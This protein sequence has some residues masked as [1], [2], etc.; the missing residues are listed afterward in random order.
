[1]TLGFI[2]GI[3]RGVLLVSIAYLLL[4]VSVQPNDRPAWIR[5]AKSEPYLQQGADLLR[6]MLP[7]QF[8]LRSASAAD[9]LIRSVDPRDDAAALAALGLHALQHRGQEAAGIVAYDGEQFSAHRG[10]GL[11][12]D[13][14]S[15][16]EVID[17][18]PG[19][20][21]IGHV[22][23]ATT[24][25]VAPRNIQPL[26]ADFEFGGLA[27]CHNGNLTNSY[28]LRRQLVRR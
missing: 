11:V 9:E 16:K 25:E 1:R 12:S 26:F 28:Q 18:L 24:G 23:Y 3:A 5:E 10:P 4:D 20:A 15:S 17:R 22:R 7:E 21:A 27:I 6:T 2:F 19:S 14:F 8:K 13:N